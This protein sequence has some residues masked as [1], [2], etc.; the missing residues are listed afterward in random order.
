VIQMDKASREFIGKFV[1]MNLNF[2][3]ADVDAQATAK[4]SQKFSLSVDDMS[5]LVT[6]EDG[7][8]QVFTAN[9]AG[10]LVIS[11]ASSHDA[12]GD[13]SVAYTLDIVPTAMFSND[14]ELKLGVGYVLDFLKGSLGAGVKLPLGELL[15]INADWLTVDVPLVDVALGPL[16]RVQGDLDALDIDLFESRFQLDAGSATYANA[17]DVELV[18]VN[19]P[20]A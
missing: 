15:G 19:N 4:F 13:G 6:L 8:K 2:Q 14:T 17:V 16:L 20:I 7:E 1:D 12:N 18:G 11:N 9:G 10:K 5:Y 3:A